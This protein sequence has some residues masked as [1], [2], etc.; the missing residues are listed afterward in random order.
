MPDA[1][2]RVPVEQAAP[3]ISADFFTGS[4]E[5]G[6]ERIRTRLLDLTNRNKLLNFRHSPASSLRVV[7]VPIDTVFRQLRE[8]EK[9]SFRPVPEPHGVARDLPP[10]ADHAR[11]LGWNISFDLRNADGKAQALPVL[12]YHEHLDTLSRKIASAAKTAIEESGTNMLYLVFGFLE[13]YESDDS[14]QPHLAPLVVLPVTIE[15][16]GGKAR[17]VEAVVEYSGEDVETNLSLVEK[18]RRD[19]GLEVPTLEDEDSPEIYFEKFA[20]IL[21]TKNTWKIRRHITLALLSFGKLLMYRDLDP[22]NWPADQNLSNHPLVRELFE[23]TKNPE[24]ALAEEYPIDAPE[25]VND[26]PHLIRDADSSQHSALIHALRGQNLVIEGPP[27]TGKSQTITN[28]IAAALAK[29]KTVLF[30]AEKLAALEVVRRRLDDAGLGVFCLEVHSHKTKKGALLADLE[31]RCKA[32]GTF[33]EPRDLD[34]HLSIVDEKK[35][36]LTEYASLVNKNIEPFRATGFEILWARDRCGQDIAKRLS[37]LGHIILPV[38]V[39]FTRTEFTQAE[40]F[41]SVYAQHLAAVLAP[42]DAIDGHPWGWIA[43]PLQFEAEDRVTGLL[44]EFLD[45]LRKGDDYCERLQQV[46]AIT[47]TRT[48]RGLEHAGAMLTLLPES[49]DTIVEQLLEPCK[50]PAN[51]QKLMDFAAHVDSFR[52]GFEK[53]SAY[54]A[55]VIPLLDVQTASGLSAALDCFRQWGLECHASADVRKFLSASAETAKHLE[56]ARSSFRVL[57][58]LIGCDAAASL[59]SAGFL[60]ET[61]RLVKTAPIELLHLRLPAFEHE[62]A[63]S[64]L[65]TAQ[66]EAS[67]LKSAEALLGRD[68]DLTLL[69]KNHSPSGLRRFASVLEEA[70]IWRRILGDEYREAVNAYRGVVRNRKKAPRRKMSRALTSLADYEQQRIQFNNHAVYSE[71]LGV[72]FRGV[73]SQWEE[74]QVVLDWYEQVFVALP[75]HQAPSEPFRRMLFTAR[76]ERFKTIKA[77]LAS[78]EEHRATLQQIVASA[79]ELTRI[80]VSSQGSPILSVS[81][82]EISTCLKKRL[83]EVESALLSVERVAIREDV[84]LRELTSLLAAAEQCRSAISAT[85]TSTDVPALI[86]SAYHGVN[87]DV[88]PIKATVRLAESISSGSLPPNT[89]DWLLC[90]EYASRF[91]DLRKWLREAQHCAGKIRTIGDDLATLSGAAFW[92]SA[93]DNAWGSLQALAE[94]SLQNRDELD[95]WN[96]FLR[97]RIQS[98]ESGL[99]K[100]TTLAEVRT[101]EPNE[102]VPAFHFTF[103]N[104][105]ARS[106]FTNHAGLSQ[107]TGL[108]QEQL[109]HQFATADREAIRL[110]SERVAAIIDQ[111]PVPYGNQSGP[112]R[113]WTEMALV[114]N[115]MNKQK[116]HIPIRQLVNRSANALLALKPCFMM[117]PLSVAQ[118][119]APG[120]LKFDLVVMDEASQLKPEDAIGALARGG[121]IVIVG[122]PKQLP[123]TTFF[124]R[125]SVDTEDDETEDDRTAVEEG[126]SILDVASTLFQ[127]VRRLRWH[128]RSRHHSLIAFSNNEFYQRDLIIFPSAYHDDPSLGVK[129][130]FVP[131]GVFENSRNPCEAA[132]VVEAALEHMRQHPDETLGIV[133]LNF[134]QRE[135]VEELLDRQLR[136]DPAAIAYQ[137]K[138]TGGQESLF[139]KNLENVQGDE[140]DVIFISTTYGPDARG[141]QYQRFGPINGPSGHRRLNVLF[142]R[143]KKRTVVFSS[144]DAERIQTTAS[145]PWGVRALK[146]YLIFA[147]TGILQ[148]ADDGGDQPTNDFERSVGTVLKESGYEIVP[149]VGVGGFFIDLGVKH[150]VKAGAFLVGIECDGASYHSGRSAR[151][152]DRLR[153]EIL[154]NLGWKIHRVWSTDWFKNREGEIKRML[155]Y[156]EGL[157]EG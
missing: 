86:G 10:A 118:Y 17:A 142:T 111:R 44:N 123:P 103:Y 129:Y 81:F 83:H 78:A 116:R 98:R 122:D 130:H 151:D 125:T 110:Y 144:L 117:G 11:E 9:L 109:R 15:R 127:P 68:F 54:T 65:Q 79:P 74:L 119:L 84:A 41:L 106:V 33:R 148:Q 8:T 46:A 124:Q 93:A 157:L 58:T 45:V 137:E 96:H 16:A 82:E 85:Q 56:E 3:S 139:I 155:R 95:S 71:M 43:A 22:K 91:A 57:L 40:H 120:Q 67:A 53:V 107:V 18:M 131:D 141:N 114:A 150:P 72:H 24:I 34:R 2:N 20:D 32:R 70:P 113:T 59:S 19:F 145:S 61:I 64:L 21:Q 87:T 75:E 99:E 92:S 55:S 88:R 94:Y 97:L 76:T 126:E 80:I 147:R 13:W 149:Q 36:V 134:D 25:L 133:T 105:L 102:L 48:L 28:L 77:N 112:V 27:G 7:D 38:V 90:P 35:R 60:L 47:L 12:H 115:E 29:S 138:M 101:L 49:E 51:R 23:G 143:A 104:T 52:G 156:V 31:Q 140:R 132:V 121:Q 69:E 30:V 1:A 39:Q 37:T 128:Y 63:R 154:E 100:L 4:T 136:D 50:S 146:Q 26:V 14:E 42:C 108:T 5:L 89:I 6:L 73:A 153:Q 62:L 66:E 152:R 135:L